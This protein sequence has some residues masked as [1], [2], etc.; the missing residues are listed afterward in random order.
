MAKDG[1][2]DD[3][4]DAEKLCDLLIGGYLRPVHHS[5]SLERAVFKRQVTLYHDRVE[6]RVSEANKIIGRSEG[7][8]AWW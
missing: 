5:E 2:K 6:H 8:G 7:G 1:D 4:I 3:P